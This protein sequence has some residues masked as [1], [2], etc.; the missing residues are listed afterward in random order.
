MGNV[1]CLGNGAWPTKKSAWFADNYP[2]I[3]HNGFMAHLRPNNS[4]KPSSL[5]NRKS[6]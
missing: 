5:H 2:R 6:T 4:G 3:A 1:R